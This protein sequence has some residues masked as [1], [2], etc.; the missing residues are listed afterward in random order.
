MNH[1]NKPDAAPVLCDVCGN[2]FDRRDMWCVFEGDSPSKCIGCADVESTAA[3]LFRDVA[4]D[5]AKEGGIDAA[6]ELRGLPQAL[7]SRGYSLRGG[8]VGQRSAV[9]TALDEY[10]TRA[11]KVVRGLLLIVDGRASDQ[12][13]VEKAREFLDE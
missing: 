4:A 11:K 7:A 2:L 9:D 5:L 1:H 13:S 10:Q 6:R 3:A 12:A 8:P